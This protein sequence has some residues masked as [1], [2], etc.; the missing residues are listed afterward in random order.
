MRFC[1]ADA[2]DAART[3]PGL[4]IEGAAQRD[5][6]TSGLPGGCTMDERI[7]EVLRHLKPPTGF[8]PWHGGPTAPKALRGVSVEVASWRPYPDRHTIWELAL[9]VAY[10]SHAVER[11]LL[12]R[13]QG[14]FPRSP[15]DWPKPSLPPTERAWAEDRRLVR[16]THES[17]AE[18][19]ASF[20]PSRLGQIAGGADATTFADLITGA[21]LHDTYHAGQIQLM[22][23]LAR[24]SSMGG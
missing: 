20:D 13:P 24:S 2:R 8:K 9:H 1:R 4:V 19:V 21:L 15:A 14:D 12:G 11:R 18:A 7:T 6:E 10:W 23:R 16:E 22:K 17:L 3:A 5:S